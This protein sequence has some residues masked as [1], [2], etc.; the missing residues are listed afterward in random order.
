MNKIINVLGYEQ[1]VDCMGCDIAN[2]KLIPPG[3][4]VYDDGFINVAAD[5]E[6]PIKGF[7]ILGIKTHTNTLNELSEAQRT[8]VMKVLD[9]T[10]RI[11][12]KVGISEEVLV[13][14]EE[15]ASHIHIWIM[16]ILKWMEKYN[17]NIKN[18]KEIFDYAKQNN[19]EENKREILDC[20]EKIKKEFEIS[21][22]K[23]RN[24]AKC[25]L[26]NDDEILTIKY[27]DDNKKAG[28]YDI[29]GG[30]IEDGETAE[31][32]ALRELKEETGIIAKNLK[33]KGI[34][35]VEYPDRIFNFKIFLSTEFNGEISPIENNISKWVKIEELLKEPKILSNIALL[36]R[37]FITG[38]INEKYNFNMY[39]MVDEEENIL[40]LDFEIV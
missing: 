4:Y 3:G 25:Y 35:K 5:P 1:I 36:D 34:L 11:I 16:P 6:I 39:I 7:M 26:I 2:H 19:N 15:R 18:I 23:I 17:K 37:K 27:K 21:E 10:I 28:Y 9:K 38:L 31:Q 30:K 24:A 29:P 12:K 13:V 33:N 20:V 40:K 8:Q 32:A 14:Q 22:K